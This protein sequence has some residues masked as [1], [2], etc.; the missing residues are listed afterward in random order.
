LLYHYLAVRTEKYPNVDT[1]RLYVTGLSSGGIGAFD[2]L[3]KYEYKFAGAVPISAGWD[4]NMFQHKQGV[5]VWAFYN[6]DEKKFTQDSCEKSM[7]EIIKN[8]GV[9]RKTVFNK[10]GHDAWSWA[11]AEPELIPWLFKQSLYCP[12]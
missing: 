3:A 6:D 4:P 8:G 11:Y 12:Q 7:Q 1:K 2:A 5:A 9:A 10:K